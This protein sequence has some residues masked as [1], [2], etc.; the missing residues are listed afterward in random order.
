MQDNEITIKKAKKYNFYIAVAVIVL[1][2][3]VIMSAVYWSDLL[4]HGVPWAPW[5]MR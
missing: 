2:V 1:I 3:A 5:D 4:S